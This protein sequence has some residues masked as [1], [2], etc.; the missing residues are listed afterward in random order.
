MIFVVQY[1]H[2]N[3][4]VDKTFDTG[5]TTKTNWTAILAIEQYC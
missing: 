2:L 3:C 4:A 1:K 5:H